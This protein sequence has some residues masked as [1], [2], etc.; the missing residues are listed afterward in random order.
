MKSIL[1]IILSIVSTHVFAETAASAQLKTYSCETKYDLS[2][3]FENSLQLPEDLK[4]PKRRW[5]VNSATVENAITTA[6]LL[7]YYEG[8]EENPR[9]NPAEYTTVCTELQ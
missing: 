8:R 3:L 9:A 4:R 5:Y 1:F 2:I 6:Q 7:A